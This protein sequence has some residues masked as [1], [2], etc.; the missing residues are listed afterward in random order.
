V[1]VLLTLLYL[2]IENIKIGPSLPA[3]VSPAVLKVLVEKFKVAPITTAD[4][5]LAAALA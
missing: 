2:G 5:D 1:A 3:F 4:A